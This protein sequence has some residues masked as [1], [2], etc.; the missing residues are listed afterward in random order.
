M[1][2]NRIKEILEEKGLTQK[3]LSDEIG[4]SV[5]TVN[6]WCSNKSQ[7]SIKTLFQIA[8]CLKFQPKELLNELR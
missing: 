7:P 5:V 3:W 8:D 1:K 2:Y 6:F 4:V